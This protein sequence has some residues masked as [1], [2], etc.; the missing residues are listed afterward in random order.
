MQVYHDLSDDIKT[1]FVAKIVWL[2][3]LII[4]IIYSIIILALY[5]VIN[6]IAG[7][8][9]AA[10]IFNVIALPCTIIDIYLMVKD[11]KR[12]S[13]A[14]FADIIYFI[15]GFMIPMCYWLFIGLGYKFVVY[16]FII[17]LPYTIF[18]GVVILMLLAIGL[19][20][21]CAC[22]CAPVIIASGILDKKIEV[23]E[24]PPGS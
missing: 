5:N 24:K 11:N 8:L 21:L 19:A 17:I 2:H 6:H 18:Y 9:I 20:Y 14:I 23:V 1:T 12:E 16:E 10:L 13:D 7:A 15:F 4:F 22:L 3:L